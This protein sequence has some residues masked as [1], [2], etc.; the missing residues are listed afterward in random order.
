MAWGR[1]SEFFDPA[2]GHLLY[3]DGYD[4]LVNAERIQVID[5][6]DPTSPCP[7]SVIVLYNANPLVEREHIWLSKTTIEELRELSNDLQKLVRLHKMPFKHLSFNE[8]VGFFVYTHNEVGSMYHTYKPGI[9]LDRLRPGM[10][11]E[12]DRKRVISAFARSLRELHENEIFYYE[13]IPVDFQYDYQED[14]I[15]CSPNN[16]LRFSHAQTNLSRELV[17]AAYTHPYILPSDLELFINNYEG[18]SQLSR[19]RIESVLDWM[20]ELERGRDPELDHFWQSTGKLAT[21]MK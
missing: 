2:E 15:I 3:K 10:M 19:K 14:K 13:P 16:C 12:D 18:S 21:L 8:P 6:I 7:A 9:R 20:R 11:A 17:I 1:T 5:Q 4:G